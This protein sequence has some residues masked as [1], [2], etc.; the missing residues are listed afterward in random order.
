M[1]FKIKRKWILASSFC[2]LLLVVVS[3]VFFPSS[4]TIDGAVLLNQLTSKEIAPLDLFYS[5]IDLQRT[6]GFRVTTKG[7]SPLV[8][9]FSSYTEGF[10][11]D[12]KFNETLN[13]INTYRQT[14]G[15]SSISSFYDYYE[16]PDYIIISLSGG[17]ENIYLINPTTH[18][19]HQPS[20]EENDNLGPMYVSHIRRVGNTY[21][22]L[23]GAF[24]LNRSYVYEMNAQTLR[25]EKASLI[26]THPSAIHKEH[27]TL[28]SNGNALF[29]NGQSLLVL[30]PDTT[31]AIALPLPFEPHAVF[32]DDSKVITFSLNT[33]TADYALFNSDLDRVLTGSLPLPNLGVSL[34]TAFLKNEILYMITFDN[35]HPLYKNYI[36]LYNL[37]TNKPI[38]C[39]ALKGHADLA[40]L[41]AALVTP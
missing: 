2:L 16:D 25:I 10:I 13:A 14:Q 32:S 28:D 26:D 4:P 6:E 38:Y 8:D 29:I 12:K 41:D 34:V 15:L 9:S 18:K 27:Y 23:G 7:L 20:F 31:Q 30:P 24:N 22:I 37:E 5:T 40:L 21:L 11:T 1:T 33:D 36:M 39:L 3:F 35:H 19:V 17:L